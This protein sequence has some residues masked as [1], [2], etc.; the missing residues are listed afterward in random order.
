M[1]TLR[2]LLLALCLL[3]PCRALDWEP[4][5]EF[6]GWSAHDLGATGR[7][8]IA[9]W[10]NGYWLVTPS[11][12][13]LSVVGLCH[14][15]VPRPEERAAGDR[16][17]AKF[18]NDPLLYGRD[19]LTWMRGAGFNTFSYGDPQGL[20][21]DMNRLGE[22]NLVPGFING[23]R[24]V[25][26]FDPAWR[27]EGAAR[28]S[29]VVPAMARDP[30][31]IGYVLSNPLLFSPVMERPAIWQGGAIKR[32][33]YLMAIKA[34]PR[35]APGKRAYVDYLRR[36]YG[37]IAQYTRRRGGVAKAKDFDD[38]L[39]AD[40]SAGDRYETLH[41]D[42]AAFYTEM[43]GGLTS[44]FVKEIRKY[45]PNGMIFSYRFIRV[46]RWPD[47]WLEAMLKGAGPHVNAVAVELYG[48][49]AYRE[50]VDGIGRITAKPALIL[51][52]MRAK[53]FTYAEEADDRAEARNY[54][55]MYRSL[56]ASPWFLG[57]AICQYRDQLPRSPYY[58]PRPGT[59]RVGIRH[60]DFTDRPPMLACY[61][62]L[63]SQKY[64][65]RVS[66]LGTR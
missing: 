15:A 5:D 33:N 41:P 59:P 19:L 4:V 60:L 50:I 21:E 66:S 6:G 40:L 9:S 13:P 37:S 56:L 55:R 32:Q 42:D 20:N 31:I 14:A 39:D 8:R 25:D 3:L 44:F 62:E 7:F 57:S 23:V 54:G 63:H 17:E 53:E 27:A 65:L 38:L 28:I 24:F 30:R 48:D 45:D 52:G 16:F 46:M 18:G 22:L 10:N 36:T 34:L 58:S 35:G 43:W 2:Y 1:T 51:D 26:L 12:H 29:R 49:N 11:G 64:A 47:P 61:R